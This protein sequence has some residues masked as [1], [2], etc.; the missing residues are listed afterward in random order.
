[1]SDSQNLIE[2]PDL[3][4]VPNLK[5]LIL[6]RCIRLYKIHASL[7]DLKRLILLDMNKCK[8]LE[9]LPHNISWNAIETFILPGCSRLKKFPEVV[10]NMLYLSVLSLNETA[11]T[12]L[13]LS[14][15]HL[16]SLIKLDLRD[17][18]N[19]SS[20]P[21]GCYSSMSLKIF[22]LSGCSKLDH[23]PENFGQ[24]KDLEQLYLS[25]TAV[26]SLPS[27]FFCLKNLLELSVPRCL[28]LSSRSSNFL[29]F[30]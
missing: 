8:R 21:S 14:V 7:G 11:I 4:G 20:L 3:S 27:S 1:M 13:P 10:R 17:C 19:L 15:K 28:V 25:G 30:P 18:K 16:T 12:G 23:L 26:T 22:D 24:I 29:R 5:Q 6:R 9:S 2:T